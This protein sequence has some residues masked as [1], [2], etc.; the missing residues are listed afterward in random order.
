MRIIWHDIP[1]YRTEIGFVFFISSDVFE[2]GMK[3]YVGYKIGKSDGCCVT[4]KAS[5]GHKKYVIYVKDRNDY[6]SL[7]HELFHA[8]IRILN[9]RDAFKRTEDD[10]QGAYLCGY[11]MFLAMKHFKRGR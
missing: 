3:K 1:L 6:E 7:V 11:L 9:D 8:A 10:E 4:L 5:N 2:K